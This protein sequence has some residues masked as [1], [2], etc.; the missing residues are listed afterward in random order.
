[1]TSSRSIY[2]LAYRAYPSCT[3]PI[4]FSHLL[5][6]RA[7][8]EA[9]QGQT[10]PAFA[11]IGLFSFTLLP[12]VLDPRRATLY[13]SISAENLLMP[14]SVSIRDVEHQVGANLLVC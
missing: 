2:A 7:N 8:I 1:M 6:R 12:I 3:L 11:A 4:P 10:S 9:F 5:I 14:S 13:Y